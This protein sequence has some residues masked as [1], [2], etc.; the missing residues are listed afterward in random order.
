MTTVFSNLKFGPLV[1]MALSQKQKVVV[2]INKKYQYRE[3]SG[4]TQSYIEYYGDSFST[5]DLTIIDGRSISQTDLLG[6]TIIYNFWYAACRPCIAEMPVLNRLATKYNTDSILFIGI[7]FDNEERIKGF[8]Q[9]HDY[10]F[11]ISSL[12][13]AEIDKIKKIAFYPF[14]AIVTKKGKLSFALC[15]HSSGKNSDVELFNLLDKQIEKALLE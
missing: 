10:A 6:K 12:P 5:P 1:T 15:C 14:T 8:L 4:I 13:Q 2:D 9:K 7:T 3:G 11:L